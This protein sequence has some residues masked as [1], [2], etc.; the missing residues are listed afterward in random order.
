MTHWHIGC[1]FEIPGLISRVQYFFILYVFLL[2]NI[3]VLQG[4]EFRFTYSMYESVLR[5]LKQEICWKNI[6]IEIRE[7]LA[8]YPF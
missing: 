6:A 5:F 4:Q 3:A 2:H 7:L 8:Q 1:P